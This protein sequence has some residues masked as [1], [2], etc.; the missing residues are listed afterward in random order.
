MAYISQ[1][2]IRDKKVKQTI[3][4]VRQKRATMVK[5]YIPYC[6]ISNMLVWQTTS[7]IKLKG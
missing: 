1:Q 5:I 4:E 7:Y 6:P 3:V 2:D